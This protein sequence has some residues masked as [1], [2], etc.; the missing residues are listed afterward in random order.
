MKKDD[1][2]NS[3]ELQTTAKERVNAL[4]EHAVHHIARHINEVDG[5]QISRPLHSY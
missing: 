5:S 3:G 2:I 1:L 4:R